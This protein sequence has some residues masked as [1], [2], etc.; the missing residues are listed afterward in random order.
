MISGLAGEIL[1][2]IRASR[3]YG[4]RVIDCRIMG[5]IERGTA[6]RPV[7]DI[8]V[9]VVFSNNGSSHRHSDTFF[10]SAKGLL[11]NLFPDSRIDADMGELVLESTTGVTIELVPALRRTVGGYLIVGRNGSWIRTNPPLK[12]AYTEGRDRM[13]D[14]KF[15]PMVRLLKKWR[16]FTDVPINSWHVE[17]MAGHILDRPIESYEH[18]MLRFFNAG[19]TALDIPDP[20][21]IGGLFTT[22][23]SSDVR[24]R[25]ERTFDASRQTVD[26]A[27]RSQVSG[28][29]P[30]CS[31][32]W[33]S[34]FGG[35]FSRLR[36]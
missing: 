18:A 26:A 8:D 36:Q 15:R 9:L 28:D 34:I 33:S 7:K 21:G 16:T 14:G 1:G 5:S 10:A 22:E 25:I 24:E 19:M 23:M 3:Y 27:L 17:A 11:K 30:A 4:S 31:G 13:L 12:A 20:D 35:D 32:Y 6:I 2:T 29:L